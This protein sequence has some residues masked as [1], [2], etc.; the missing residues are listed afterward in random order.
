ML[1]LFK[2]LQMIDLILKLLM[3]LLLMLLL[4]KTSSSLRGGIGLYFEHIQSLLVEMRLFESHYLISEV[5]PTKARSSTPACLK[6]LSLG[7]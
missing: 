7:C 5:F 4:L 1:P 6:S 2:A 3:M